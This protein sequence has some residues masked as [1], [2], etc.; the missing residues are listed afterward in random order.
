[1]ISLFPVLFDSGELKGRTDIPE[2]SDCVLVYVSLLLGMCSLCVTL[3]LNLSVY[4]VVFV[5]KNNINI[6]KQ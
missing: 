1:M 3:K 5:C 2:V 4:V 6:V